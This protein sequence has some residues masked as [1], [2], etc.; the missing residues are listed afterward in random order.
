MPFLLKLS[1]VWDGTLLSICKV[2]QSQKGQRTETVN[3]ANWQ[4]TKCNKS[5]SGN[6]L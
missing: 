5:E 4:R 3:Y 6:K 1:L 2:K